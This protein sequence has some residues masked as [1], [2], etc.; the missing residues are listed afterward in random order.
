[1]ICRPAHAPAGGIVAGVGSWRTER[2]G[3]RAGGSLVH[4][5]GVIDPRRPIVNHGSRSVRTTPPR[6]VEGWSAGPRSAERGRAGWGAGAP[7]AAISAQTPMKP[8]ATT[9]APAAASS[10]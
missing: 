5:P 10:T 3:R 8:I 7:R 2:S 6:R 1:M 9:S 4:V